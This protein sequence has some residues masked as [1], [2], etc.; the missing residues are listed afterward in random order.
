MIVDLTI[1]FGID[2]GTEPFKSKISEERR[3][4][5]RLLSEKGTTAACAIMYDAFKPGG[6]SGHPLMMRR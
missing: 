5:E 6:A 1:H 2:P 3:K 4:F